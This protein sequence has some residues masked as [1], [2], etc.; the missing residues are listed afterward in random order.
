MAYVLCLIGVLGILGGAWWSLSALAGY[1]AYSSSA[2]AGLTLV[3]VLL[4]G[5]GTM[6]SGLLM[7]AGGEALFR[8]ADLV[9]I[10]GRTESAIARLA[11][12]VR[13]SAKN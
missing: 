2:M 5:L 3:A 7:L 6:V 1:T 9:R 12:A 11:D 4:P 10:S 8:L 13:Q